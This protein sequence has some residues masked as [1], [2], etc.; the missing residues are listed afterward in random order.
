ML[1]ALI[2]ALCGLATV[3]RVGHAR[4]AAGT[5]VHREECSLYA[6]PGTF[7]KV[8][9]VLLQASTRSHLTETSRKGNSRRDRLSN[10]EA[11]ESGLLQKPGSPSLSFLTAPESTAKP[12]QN[13]G[14]LRGFSKMNDSRAL[15]YAMCINTLL[16]LSCVSVFC[17][18]RRRFPLVYANN[19][20]EE[21]TPFEPRDDLLGWVNASY[22]LTVEQAIEHVGLDRAMFLEFTHLCLR[23]LILASVPVMIVIY[24]LYYLIG[25][26]T[27]SKNL[28][29]ELKPRALT[30][31]WV[32]AGT[33]WFTVLVAEGLI[34]AANARFRR[35]RLEWLLNMPKP[36]ATTILVEGI[37][38]EDQSDTRLRARFDFAL[39]GPAVES[40]YVVRRSGDV[41]DLADTVR[42]LQ[43]KLHGYKDDAKIQ[44]KLEKSEKAMEDALVRFKGDIKSEDMTSSGFVTF[45]RRRDA[46]KAT[47]LPLPQM[48]VSRAPQPEDVRFMDFMH[49]PNRA[50]H[51]KVMGYILLV[52]IWFGFTPVLLGL[53]TVMDL[54]TLQHIPI[55]G[56]V[57]EFY[58]R[59]RATWDA[60]AG[61]FLLNLLMGLVPSLFALVI[62]KC[63][64]EKSNAWTQHRIQMWMFPF[65]LTFVLLVVAA[66]DA[67]VSVWRASAVWSEILDTGVCS[68]LASTLP[69]VSNF[70]LKFVTLEL[71][72]ESMSLTRYMNLFKFLW[73]RRK[74][75]PEK[76]RDFAE[77][78]DQD[79]DGIGNRCA[80]S[81][82][83]LACILVFSVIEPMMCILGLLYFC[84][85][86]IYYGYL[87][88]FAET[89]KPDLGGVFWS[90]QLRHLHQGLFIYVA[91][92]VGMLLNCSGS[93]R[94][95]V[96]T[97]SCFVVLGFFSYRLQGLEWEIPFEDSHLD[98]MDMLRPSDPFD[99]TGSE[100]KTVRFASAH[101]YRA[102]GARPP[103]PGYRQPELASL[104]AS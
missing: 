83:I 9:P 22:L 12:P 14:D 5:G 57:V 30:L 32:Q 29:P 60:L 1:G 21:K 19:V 66:G 67:F 33:V 51:R 15:W 99:N 62:G 71:S 77:P 102:S 6:Q 3:P 55:I 86:R 27:C 56:Y 82:L 84:L 98:D 79:V 2:V 92:M 103:C 53:L 44:A 35:R 41:A 74:Y 104:Y 39:Q 78:E 26:E 88:V 40:A 80:R 70:Y 69:H 96:V 13:A 18:L 34:Q 4:G 68:K 54:S 24:P 49:D 16:A 75:G 73:W 11:E 93:H 58:P 101:S 91:L 31:H 64:G 46:A 94:P 72:V 17:W 8:A 89:H 47:H 95:A 87:L 90:A 97:A 42:E 28:P 76:A 10:E 38:P 59:S 20:L 81:S 48:R 36:W 63:L 43:E 7:V 52:L 45:H 25:P 61:S 50:T 100:S 37:P 23:L 85:V 65:L